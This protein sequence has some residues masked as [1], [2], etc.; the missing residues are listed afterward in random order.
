MKQNMRKLLMDQTADLTAASSIVA[1]KKSEVS[2][3]KPKT[4]P[5]LMAA[6]SAAQVRIKELEGQ[7]IAAEVDTNKVR[8]NPFQPRTKFDEIKLKELAASIQAIGLLQAVLVRRVV[9]IQDGVEVEWFELIAGERRWR[10][11]KLVNIEKIKVNVTEASDVDMAVLALA[12][13]VSRE[14][15][16]D[17]EI[18]KGIYRIEDQFPGRKAMAAEIGISRGNLYRYLA[19]KELP[20]YMLMDL[21]VTP[22]LLGGTQA[23]DIVAVLKKYGTDAEPTAR[24]FWKQLK[25]EILEQSKFAPLLE[26]AM[27]RKA[28]GGS[29]EVSTQRDIRKLYL[30]KKQ[31]GSITKDAANFS[32]KLKATMLDDAKE[33]RIRGLIGELF[34]IEKEPLAA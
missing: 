23:S 2:D 27:E 5:G 9:V 3:E 13:N 29:G 14:D 6:L 24:E 16:T 28:A 34:E 10:A 8:P 33:E 26:S 30:G 18:A 31:A 21:D 11:H 19:F 4:A 17:Y 22:D 20:S 7:S 32:I 1:E 12:E 25:A 15:L